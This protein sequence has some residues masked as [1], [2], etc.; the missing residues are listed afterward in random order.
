ME[1]GS[2]SEPAMMILPASPSTSID[3]PVATRSHSS[4][5]SKIG[6][7]HV[8]GVAVK[9]PREAPGNDTGNPGCLDRDGGMLPG[10]PLPKFSP[11]TMISPHRHSRRTV[12]RDP[13]CSDAPAPRIGRC[14][15]TA[16]MMASVSI[17]SPNFQIFPLN[18]MVVLL[19]K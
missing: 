8:E 7:P 15:M 1:S 5:D 14:Q 11:A 13:P 2:A 16:G 12:H 3:C 17:L 18:F 19:R 4:V 6:R 10:G 9:D